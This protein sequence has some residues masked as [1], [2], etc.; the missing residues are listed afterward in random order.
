MRSL[1]LLGIAAPDP[2]GTRTFP[3]PE[4]W[5]DWYALATWRA[6]RSPV[7]R[8]TP[9]RAQGLA[10]ALTDHEIGPQ[11]G[12][13]E[14]TAHGIH[15]LDHRLDKVGTTLFF[16][17]L[18]VSIAQILGYALSETY[19]STLGNWFTLVSA[20]FPALGTAI[21][22]IRYQGDFGA[23]AVRSQSTSR[24]LKAID[25]ELRKEPNLLRTADLMEEAARV[26]L[27]DLD[28]WSLS[29]EQRE[30]SI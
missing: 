11:V 5:V 20:G 18:L 25:T 23:T 19:V 10:V 21:F 9:E 27:G 8:I 26:M 2:P 30:L 16:A 3:V 6:M 12:Y 15:L 22:G 1:K 28:E 17:T 13:H 24:Q 29:N 4:R 7:A 14:R